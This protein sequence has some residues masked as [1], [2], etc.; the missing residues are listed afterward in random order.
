MIDMDSI[1][2]KLNNIFVTVFDNPS[3]KIFPETTADDIEEWDS[4]SHINLIM[5][6]EMTFSV[7]FSQKEV[8]RFRN[9]ADMASCIQTKV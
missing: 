1:Y 3:L 4:F 7:E 8:M 6:I 2:E 9:V 5:M